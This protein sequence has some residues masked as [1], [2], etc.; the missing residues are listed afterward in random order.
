MIERAGRK[1]SPAR[2]VPEVLK[3][4][5]SLRQQVRYLEQRVRSLQE[6]LGRIEARQIA[7]LPP[8]ASLQEREFR[9]Y[10]QWGEDGILQHL[11]GVVSI[12]RRVFVEFG[13]ESYQE[14]NTRFLLVNDNWAGL[15]IDGDAGE[16]EQVRRSREYW[17]YNLKAA[18]AFITRENINA[19][20]TEHGVSGEIGLL[21]IDLDGMDYW[22]WDAIDVIDPAIVVV[23]YNSRF[24]PDDA[25]TVPYDPQFD[26]RRAHHSLLY[27]GASLKALALLGKRK[28]YSLVGCGS[29]GLNAFFVRNDLRPECLPEQTP[30]EAYLVGQFCEAHDADGTR[31]KMSHEDQMRLVR[32][33]PL[34][35]VEDREREQAATVQGNGHA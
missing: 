11:T 30:E 28:G 21:S 8:G 4:V 7:A 29:A 23:E 17:L 10:S 20:L 24:G 12:E 25:V 1:L 14:A 5:C 15:V 22:V 32:G 31:I 33:L 16:I 27:Y 6:A 9:V 2:L 26:R 34:V 13:V 35:N 18:H 19:L 3:Q